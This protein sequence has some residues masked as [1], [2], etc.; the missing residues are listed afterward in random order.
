[1]TVPP[2]KK[3]SLNMGW[4]IGNIFR[5][6][7]W[8]KDFCWTQ[9]NIGC[10][11]EK[12]IRVNV[13]VLTIKWLYFN[14]SWKLRVQNQ[15]MKHV[16]FLSI[17]ILYSLLLWKK[18]PDHSITVRE[19]DHTLTP[20]G[21]II[22]GFITEIGKAK[23]SRVLFD[24]NNDST[25]NGLHLCVWYGCKNS[26]ARKIAFGLRYNYK[27]IFTRISRMYLVYYS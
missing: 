4:N 21:K 19:T 8:L 10:P 12:F 11:R 24:G 22:C 15:M 7:L 3:S 13:V 18:G 26:Q 27:N 17:S 16:V 14:T 23:Q 5:V 20:L 1:M 2:K 25:D 9:V 6:L